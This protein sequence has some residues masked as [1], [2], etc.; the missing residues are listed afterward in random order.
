MLR[1]SLSRLAP[2]LTLP[3][4]FINQQVQA[5]FTDLE[6]RGRDADGDGECSGAVQHCVWGK[7][8]SA[9]RAAARG[10]SAVLFWD[11]GELL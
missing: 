2:T 8:Q 4:T 7:L 3:P 1:L 6:R 9:A 11:G 5:S 10:G